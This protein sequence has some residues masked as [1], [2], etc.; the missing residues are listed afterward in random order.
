MRISRS[1][2]TLA[3]A[4]LTAV[5][6]TGCLG[7]KVLSETVVHVPANDPS[8]E[9]RLKAKEPADVLV[10]YND[11]QSNNEKVTRRA[12]YLFAN[13][14]NLWHGKRPKF[15]KLAEADK[16]EPVPMLEAVPADMST[17]TNEMYAYEV[18][19]RHYR[20]E[21]HGRVL[22]DFRLPEYTRWLTAKKVF[23]FPGAVGADAVGAAGV[24]AAAGAVVG[25]VAAAENPSAAEAAV[26]AIEHKH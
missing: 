4:G 1:A 22:A 2:M 26:K 18:D 11:H 19:S 5:L 13:E 15:V 16:L 10:V 23:L 24:A 6:S 25:V 9:L 7:P 12:F 3:A 21:S 17:V 20:V 8:V 14:E